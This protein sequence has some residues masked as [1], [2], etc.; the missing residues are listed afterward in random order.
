MNI[1]IS[2]A[3]GNVGIEIC[4]LLQEGHHGQQVFAGVRIP[5]KESEFQRRFPSI[6]LKE[7]DFD[8]PDK[9][10]SYLAGMDVLFFLRPPQISN[11]KKYFEPLIAACIGAK[12]KHLVFLSVQGADKSRLIPHHKIERLIRTSGIPFTFLRPAYF[13][14][15]FTTILRNDILRKNRVYL[16]AGKA[17]FTLIDVNDLAAVAVE[18]LSK[19]DPHRNKAYDLTN[20]EQMDFSGMCGVLSKVLGRKVRFVS[21]NP[22]RFFLQKRKEGVAT[23]YILVMILLHYLPRFQPTPPTSATLEQIVG[24]KAST[25]EEFVRREKSKFDDGCHR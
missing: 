22:L 1:L 10:P 16:P 20:S 14:Q 23:P 12:I 18:I 2:G 25:F 8:R 9:F 15:N 11:V 19:P 21:P 6:Q 24:R 17:K 3:T 4:K 5:Q 13:M 7:F